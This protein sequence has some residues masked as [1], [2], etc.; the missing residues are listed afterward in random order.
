MSSDA[1]VPIRTADDPRFASL[2]AYLKANIASLDGSL[3]FFQF[4]GGFSNMT[5]L[6]AA[7]DTELV[8]KAAPPG[9]KAKAA[10][11]VSREFHIMERLYG[12]FPYLPRPVLCCEDPDIFGESF[13]VMERL[14]GVVFRNYDRQV[15]PATPPKHFERLL[16]AM[17]DLH[18]VDYANA[19]LSEFGRPQGYRRRQIEGWQNRLHAARTD[20]M[21]DFDAVAGWLGQQEFADLEMAAIVHNDFKMDNLM[22]DSADSTRLIA[23]LDWEMATLGDPLLDLA[24][25]LSFW[26]KRTTRRNSARCAGCRRRRQVCS[27]VGRPRRVTGSSPDAP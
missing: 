22:W 4:P 13:C 16:E 10:H 9:K 26:I 12:R 27:R 3:G 7:G 21:A 2:E 20:D 23:V 6:I 24:Y 17:A 8:L 19:G 5:Y 25:T 15:D 14:N 18:A 11:N 1:P